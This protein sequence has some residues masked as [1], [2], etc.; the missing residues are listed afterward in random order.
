MPRGC[1]LAAGLV[2]VWSIPAIVLASG[3]PAPD[4]SNTD[5][6]L[7]AA[8]RQRVAEVTRLAHAATNSVDLTARLSA[9]MPVPATGTTT[10]VAVAAPTPPPAAETVFTLRGLS[11]AGKPLALL[12]GRWFG[13][14]DRVSA[15]GI[16]LSKIEAGRVVL[17]D[18]QGVQRVISLYRERK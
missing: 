18:T 8:V 1:A 3:A 2:A 5:D 6:R 9:Q 16:R 15:D 4:E 17:V 12:N 10:N 7:I 13:V 14:G 11:L